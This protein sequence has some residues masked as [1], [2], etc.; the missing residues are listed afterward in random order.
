MS[1]FCEF[2]PQDKMNEEKILI[3]FSSLVFKELANHGKKS[4]T[5][6]FVRGFLHFVETILWIHY[7]Y[8]GDWGS[9]GGPKITQLSIGVRWTPSMLECPLVRFIFWG[10]RRARYPNFYN[11]NMFVLARYPNL[12]AREHKIP[13]NHTQ[14][15]LN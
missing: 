8:V 11:T 10:A 3:D 7:Q 1:W 2:F 9:H 13:K 5:R 4:K 14:I 12:A 15:Y 6:Y